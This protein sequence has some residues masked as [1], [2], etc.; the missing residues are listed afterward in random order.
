MVGRGVESR[1][2]PTDCSGFPSLVFCQN[3]NLVLF[4]IPAQAGIHFQALG[5]RLRGTDVIPKLTF[6]RTLVPVQ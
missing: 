6:D 4:V 2:R 3:L 5:S 1:V